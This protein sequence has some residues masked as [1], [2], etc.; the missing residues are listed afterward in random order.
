ME[1]SRKIAQVPTKKKHFQEN[2]A[3]ECSEGIAAEVADLHADIAPSDGKERY[4]I[5][6]DDE[7]SRYAVRGYKKRNPSCQKKA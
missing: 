2:Y 5:Y 1:L 4:C 7:I 6:S 3:Y